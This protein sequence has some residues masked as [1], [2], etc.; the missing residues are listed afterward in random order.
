VAERSVEMSISEPGRRYSVIHEKNPREILLLR[1]RGCGWRRCSFCDYHLDFSRDDEAN[2][3]LNRQELQKV[4]GC[5]GKLEVINSGSFVELDSR[6]VAEIRKV[7]VEKRIH[8]L[9]M[10]FHWMYR[11]KIQEIR[12]YFAQENI[13]VKVKLGV[14]TFDSGYREKILKKGIDTD[15]PEEIAKYADEICLLFGLTG[16]TFH[17]MQ[18]DIETGLQYFERIC[19]NIMVA[20]STEI[21]PDAEVI[22][23]FKC[24]LYDKYIGNDRV[25]ILMENTEFG[26]G[27]K[28]ERTDET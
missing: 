14:E 24:E 3:Q 11:E 19:I 16:Q 13:V 8:E 25:D 22:E 28:Y 23:V 17:S 21:K 27:D 15:L 10:E 12:D 5:Y 26:V 20:N 6:T 2:Y 1:G 7:C 9:H 18:R 4:T